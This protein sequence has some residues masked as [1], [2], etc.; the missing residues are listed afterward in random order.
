[1]NSENATYTGFEFEVEGHKA[2][3]IINTDL[4]NLEDRSQYP[5]AVFIRLVPDTYTEDGYPDEKEYDFLN[6]IE[7]KI[8]HYL[9]GQTRTVHVGHT[10]IYRAREIIFYTKDSEMVSDFLEHFLETV[11]RENGFEIEQDADWDHVSA[12]YQLL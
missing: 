11:E 10:T 6:E 9:E 5:Y 7:K 2:M 12:F 3:A 8:I 4:K 1:M